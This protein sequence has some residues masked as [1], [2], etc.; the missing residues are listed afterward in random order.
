MGECTLGSLEYW[1]VYMYI[2]IYIP[3]VSI[4]GNHT[5][6]PCMLSPKPQTL[7]VRLGMMDFGTSAMRRSR[8]ITLTATPATSGRDEVIGFRV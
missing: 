7:T 8:T 1:C 6:N 5:S 2:Y 3:F 4:L